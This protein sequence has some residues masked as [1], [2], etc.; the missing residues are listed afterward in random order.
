MLLISM[1]KCYLVALNMIDNVRLFRVY[2][3]VFK[4]KHEI[5]RQEGEYTM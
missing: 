2:R 3:F 1:E 5:V 4:E